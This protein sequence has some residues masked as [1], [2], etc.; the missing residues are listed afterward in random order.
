MNASAPSYFGVAEPVRH[1]APA[2]SSP[3]AYHYC[4]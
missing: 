1:E 2:S 4:G 3:P